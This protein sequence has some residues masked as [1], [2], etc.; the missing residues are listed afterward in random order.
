MTIIV[1]TM[2]YMGASWHRA[3]AMYRRVMQPL[4]ILAAQRQ[5]MTDREFAALA[6]D[7]L[8]VKHVALDENAHVVGLA[9]A[10]PCLDQVPLISVPYYRHRYGDDLVD[11]GRVWYV[12]FVC[13]DRD[14]PGT[15]DLFA[16][17]VRG[18]AEPIAKVKGVGCLDFC[19]RNMDEVP[20][21][22]TATEIIKRAHGRDVGDHV[23][24]SQ[25]YVSW[26]F[27]DLA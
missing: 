11:A 21:F 4:A 22:P 15:R 26:D 18:I 3:Y 1:K 27:G 8:I 12:P 5:I 25:H 6:A 10:T 9:A 20:I 24:D 17:L 13:V 7:D 16:R 23:D 2:N 19:E 14:T